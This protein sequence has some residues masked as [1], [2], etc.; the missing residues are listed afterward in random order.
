MLHYRPTITNNSPYK[1][2]QEEQRETTSIHQIH[3][4]LHRNKVAVVL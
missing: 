2:K 3:S 4:S 1:C